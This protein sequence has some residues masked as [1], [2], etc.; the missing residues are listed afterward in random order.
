[1]RVGSPLIETTLFLRP[2]HYLP[3]PLETTYM[4]AWSGVPE[5]WRR[6]IEGR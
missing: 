1:M 2:E 3:V 6:V 4:S 5:R